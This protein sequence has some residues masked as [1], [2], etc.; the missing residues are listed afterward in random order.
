MNKFDQLINEFAQ[1]LSLNKDEMEKKLGPLL[2]G[3]DPK[4][5]AGLGAVGEVLNDTTENDPKDIEIKNLF[6]KLIDDNTPDDEKI[7]IKLDLIN[8]GVLPPDQ[9]QEEQE[10]SQPIKSTTNIKTSPTSTTNSTS[11]KV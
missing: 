6:D 7:K 11:Y 4:T 1:T 3:L 9:K 10:S 8:R 5:K 2:K